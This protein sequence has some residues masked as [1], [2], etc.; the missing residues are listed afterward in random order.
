MPNA[1]SIGARAI[2][3]N[4]VEQLLFATIAP[5][6]FCFRISARW[7]ALISGITSGTSESMR[8]FDEFVITMCPSAAYRDSASPATD[9]SSPDIRIRLESVSVVG[10]TTIDPTLSGIGVSCFHA[11]MSRYRRPADRSDATSSATRNRG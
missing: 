11:T 9:E 4:I 5:G 6:P 2:A 10:F 1:R 8:W 7:S 3:R